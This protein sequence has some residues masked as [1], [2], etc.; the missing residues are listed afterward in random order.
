MRIYQIYLGC[1]KSYNRGIARF[2]DKTHTKKNM[3]KRKYMNSIGILDRLIS[4]AFTFLN[5]IFYAGILVCLFYF[6]KC[7]PRRK[8]QPKK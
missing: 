5:V 8:E 4:V 7:N 1:R 6:L 3:G 2:T